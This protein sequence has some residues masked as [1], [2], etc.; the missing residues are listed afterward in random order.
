MTSKVIPPEGIVD[1]ANRM[2]CPLGPSHQAF[3]TSANILRNRVLE[4]ERE[5]ERYK[6]A[7]QVVDECRL[8]LYYGAQDEAEGATD[9]AQDAG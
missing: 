6:H 5:L 8:A 7:I 3:E 4:L 1:V 9:D 2:R